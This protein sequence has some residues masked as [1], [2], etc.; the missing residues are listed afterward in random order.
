VTEKAEAGVLGEG[1]IRE[2]SF[3]GGKI[4]KG[5]G[6]EELTPEQKTFPPNGG[7]VNQAY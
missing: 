3:A 4:K 2:N 7:D 1:M 6:S 5:N